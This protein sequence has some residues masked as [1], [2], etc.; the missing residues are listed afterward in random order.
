MSSFLVVL[1]LQGLVGLTWGKTTWQYS[2]A[3]KNL[4]EQA[5]RV[6]TA[7]RAQKVENRIN[8]HKDKIK[9]ALITQGIFQ[10][11]K[12]AGKHIND[13]SDS[14]NFCECRR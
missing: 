4:S 7:N 3:I 14:S 9:N 12:E 1:A 2:G 5:G 10:G 13:P 8:D 6:R 11:A